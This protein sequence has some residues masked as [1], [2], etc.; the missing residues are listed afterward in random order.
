MRT[1]GTFDLFLSKLV[2][3]EHVIHGEMLIIT[4]LF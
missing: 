3:S 2:S 1:W 4:S